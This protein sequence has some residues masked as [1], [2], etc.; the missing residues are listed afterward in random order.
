MVIRLEQ[1]SPRLEFDKVLRT[2]RELDIEVVAHDE[3]PTTADRKRA[4]RI[5]WNMGLED[6]ALDEAGYDALLAGVVA[7][8][9]NREANREAVAHPG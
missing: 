8:R 3:G 5:A 7:S 4:D 6:R 2:I 9:L 1:G